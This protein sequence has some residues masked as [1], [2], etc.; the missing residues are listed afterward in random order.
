MVF[1]R[2]TL[3]IKNIGIYAP[4]GGI[5]ALSRSTVPIV[6]ALLAV[7]AGNCN[8]KFISSTSLVC[9]TE[10]WFDLAVRKCEIALDACGREMPFAEHRNAGGLK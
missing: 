4:L 6:P 9:G 7:R 5:F 3:C 1:V 2:N 8:L 10:S